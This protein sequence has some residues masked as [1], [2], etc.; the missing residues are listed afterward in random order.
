MKKPYLIILGIVVVIVLIIW[1]GLKIKPKPFKT[2][3]E[4][5]IEQPD[6]F[7]MPENLPAPVERFYELVYGDKLPSIETFIISGRGRIRFQ[8]ITMPAKLRF[9]HTAGQDYRHLIET[10]FWGISI[11]K[12]DEQFV[13]WKS[14][15]ELPFG[16]VENEPKIDE[17]ANLGLWSETLMFP[18]VYLSTEGVRWVAVDESTAELIVPFKQSEDRFTVYFNTETGLIDYMETMR[19]KEAG[20]QEKTRWQAQA[21]AW[22]VID[23]LMMPTRFA[24]QWMDE[25]SPWLVADIEEAVW[26]VDVSNYFELNGLEK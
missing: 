9:I 6:P 21:L 23:G 3:T 26:N 11:L 16:V 13:D 10:T 25:D 7:Q 19:W 1:L 12:V 20:D 24:A 8:G 15:L 18:S 4:N 5:S 22:G 14:R 17:A 2:L